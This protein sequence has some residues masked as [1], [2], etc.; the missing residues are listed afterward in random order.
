[1]R[2]GTLQDGAR[3]EIN[4][5]DQIISAPNRNERREK[6]KKTEANFRGRILETRAR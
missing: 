3:R 6:K 4:T 1:M 5:P 2:L